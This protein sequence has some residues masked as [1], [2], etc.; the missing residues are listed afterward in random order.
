MSFLINEPGLIV[1]WSRCRINPSPWS[2]N[3]MLGTSGSEMTG[4]KAT[5]AGR[6][7]KNLN[8]GI[9]SMAALASGWINGDQSYTGRPADILVARDGSLL[10]A[11][12]WVG[13]IY[14]IS[15]GK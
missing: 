10:V 1:S 9:G 12:D 2:S 5:N 6:R 4:A 14:R 3:W 13:A 8:G 11:D 7:A 15:Y